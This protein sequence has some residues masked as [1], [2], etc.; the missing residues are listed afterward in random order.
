MEGNNVN[1]IGAYQ[2]KTTI[3]ADANVKIKVNNDYSHGII[4]YTNSVL[5]IYG[6]LSCEI[7]SSYYAAIAN[8]NPP[9][10]AGNTVNIHSSAELYVKNSKNSLITNN[11]QNILTISAGA[12]LGIDDNYFISRKFFR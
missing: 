7:Y 6:K 3:A 1:G 11:S 8:N 2:G 5:D 10:Y 12:K 4:N 9:S